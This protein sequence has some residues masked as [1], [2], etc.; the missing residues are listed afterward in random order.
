L[1]PPD[2]PVRP[3]WPRPFPDILNWSWRDYGNRVGVWRCLQLFDRY[4]ITGSVS[5]NAAMCERLPEIVAQFRDRDWD[6][7]SHGDY[8]TRYLFGLTPE[9]ERLAIAESCA[10]IA[11]FSGKPV[12]GFLA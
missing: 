11:K 5:L 2:N 9:Q 7:F 1:D 12:R 3:A 10:R 4:Q 6:L 8:N